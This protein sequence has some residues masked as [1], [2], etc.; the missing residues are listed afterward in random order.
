MDGWLL[1]KIAK[2]WSDN[3]SNSKVSQ[4]PDPTADI[5]LYVNYYLFH[6]LGYPETNFNVGYFTHKEPS[7]PFDKVA[8]SVD[9]CIGMSRKTYDL[10]P[11]HKRSIISPTGADLSLFPNK[12]VTIG[13]VARHYPEGRKRLNILE[14]LSSLSGVNIRLT[15]GN[16]SEADLIK[17]YDSID[18]LLVTSN[19]EGGPV[20][21][22]EALLL[23]KP[24]I[25][26]DVGWCWDFPV[27]KYSSIEEL[28][29]IVSSLGSPIIP[30]EDSSK[31]LVNILKEAYIKK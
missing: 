11:K 26:P 4:N 19:I 25:A 28:K 8:Q 27:I 12:P 24:I 7:L 31:E 17:F 13:V 18:Y 9:H 22:L 3:I 10:L 23:N 30:W 16:L 20:P 1:P 6:S 21:V 14:S 2:N 29:R 15:G 5:N